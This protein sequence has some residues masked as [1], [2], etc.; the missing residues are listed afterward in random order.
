MEPCLRTSSERE[1]STSTHSG[2]RS[3]TCPPGLGTSS[4]V[5]RRLTPRVVCQLWGSS[6]QAQR[7]RPHIHPKPSRSLTRASLR[8]G[9]PVNPRRLLGGVWEPVELAFALSAWTI[10]TLWLGTRACWRAA[11]ITGRLP[12]LFSRSLH[13]PRGHEV[14]AFGVFTCGACRAVFESHAFSPC[15]C[16]GALASHLPCP[17]CGLSIQDPLR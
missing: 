11:R 4:D 17:D 5:G 15:P 6:Q 2:K 14:P 7:D 12:Q 10:G 8:L 16:C 1:R 13:C 9:R 3:P